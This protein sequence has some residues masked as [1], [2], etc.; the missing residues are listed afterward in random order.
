MSREDA[1]KRAT[2][3]FDSGEFF[4]VLSRRV[5]I[6]TESQVEDRA[7]EIDSYLSQE[8]IPSLQGMGFACEILSNPVI[9]RLPML[10]AERI[11]APGLLTLLTY[12]HGD[13]V[14]GLD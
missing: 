8:M 3:F 13:V 10:A 14:R 1:I 2:H 12:G 6:A 5:A 9:P 11:E 4:E 7:S